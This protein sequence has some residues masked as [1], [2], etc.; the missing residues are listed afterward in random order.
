MNNDFRFLIFLSPK[1]KE[2]SQWQLWNTT[3]LRYESM[4][5]LYP[6]KDHPQYPIFTI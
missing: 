5:Q 1:I 2:P 3:L 6:Y 4:V